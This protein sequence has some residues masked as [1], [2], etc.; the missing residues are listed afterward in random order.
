MVI[1]GVNMYILTII[2]IAVIFDIIIGEF[3]SKIHPVVFMGNLITILKFW[4]K[5]YNNKI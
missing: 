5:K 4:L 2:I 3:P 1:L